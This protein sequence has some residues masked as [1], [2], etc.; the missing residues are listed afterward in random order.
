[1]TPDRFDPSQASRLSADRQ[2]EALFPAVPEQNFQVRRL[3]LIALLIAAIVLPCVYVAAMAFSDFR[4]REA[5]ATDMALRTVRVAEE[6]ALKVFDMNET[7]DSRIV[8]LAQDL[9]DD[10]ISAREADIHEKLR[11]MGGGYPQV[12]AVSI[13]GRDGRLLASSRFYPVPTLSVAGREDFTGIR[14]GRDL[15]H[16]SKVMT[17]HVA[18]EQVFNMGVER[19]GA[20]GAFAG[21][22]SVALRPSYFSAFYREL[23]GGSDGMAMTMTL[24][25]MDGAILAHYPRSPREPSAMPAQSPLA[26]AFAQGRRAGVVRTHSDIDGEKLIVAYRH[27]GSYPVY[28]L[29][30]YRASAIWAAWY[31]HLSVLLLSLFTPSIALWCVIWLSLRRLGAEEEAWERWQ[32][33][34]SM[35]RSIESAYRQSRKMEALGT[36]VGSVAHDF[37]NL[38]MIVSAN[39]QIA[40][41]RGAPG[42]DRELSAMERA[43][44]SG[45][46]LTRQLLG[47]ARKQPL[48]NET[49]ALERW[50]PACRELLRASLGAKISLVIDVAA[51]I[52]PMRVDVA[53]LELALINIAVNARDAMPNGGRFTVRATNLHFR[54]E[55]GF[56]LTGDFVQL[57]LEDTGAGMAPDVLARAFE[58]LFTTKAKGMGTG[59]GLPQVFAF[60]ERSGGLA[61][62]DSAVGAGTSVRLYLP[63]ATAEPEAEG[64][65]EARAEDSGAPHGLRILLVE[66]NEEVAAGTE[67]LLQM[68]GHQVTCV[69]NAD[70]AL[71]LFDDAHAKQARTGEPLPFDLVLSDIHMPGKMNGIDLAEAVLA[72]DTRLPVI[73]MTGYAEELDRARHVNVRVLSKPFDIALLDQLLQAIQRDLAQPDTDP[74]PHPAP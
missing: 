70:T 37:N 22:V 64:P 23:L 29:C 42:L 71:R 38:L 14:D 15:E 48:R 19:R 46:S 74:A 12:A 17:G 33:E 65:A 45:Q 63:R 2:D 7:L 61:A 30:G 44:K 10:G 26:A 27:V 51:G 40:R 66:D 8:D 6:H 52:W 73:L 43:L 62:I 41:R 36:L 9:D 47:V 32:A 31:R 60:C 39:L 16:V 18:G 24:V 28:V 56:P 1:M 55:D 72:F 35:R 25:R 68:M 5:D 20:D 59:L 54:H 53:E 50:L 69:F 11:V 67:A 58:P 57:S 49:L 4:A 3:T 21:M 13:F 34:A